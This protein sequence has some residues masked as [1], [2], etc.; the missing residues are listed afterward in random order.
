M[1]EVL[2]DFLTESHEC[3]DLIDVGLANFRQDPDNVDLLHTVFRLVHT[4]KGTCGFL[5]LPRLEALSHAAESMIYRFRLDATTIS[6]DGVTLVFK[7]LESIKHLLSQIEVHE[8][9]EPAGDDSLLIAELEEMAGGHS[10]SAGASVV[11]PGQRNLSQSDL[12]RLFDEASEVVVPVE[13]ALPSS[14]IS[15]A[16]EA[17]ASRQMLRVKV[18]SLEQLVSTVTDLITTRAH[19]LEI[20]RRSDDYELKT[21]VNRLA[22]IASHLQKIVVDTRVQPIGSAWRQLL[23]MTQNLAVRLNK[24]IALVLDGE[25]IEVDRQIIDLIKAPL[26]HMV[27]N[28]ADHGL[29]APDARLALGKPAQ[30]TI[31]VTAVRHGSDIVIEVLDDGQGLNTNKIKQKAL[32]LGLINDAE[33]SNMDEADAAQLIFEPGLSTC[34]TVTRLS[35]R[36]VGLDVAC[37]SIETI[38]GSIRVYSVPGEGTVFVI[39]IPVT[40]AQISSLILAKT[41]DDEKIVL[42]RAKNGFAELSSPSPV[43]TDAASQ[44]K[45]AS[46]PGPDTKV[47]FLEENPFFKSMLTPAIEAGGYDVTVV[48]SVSEALES[49]QADAPFLA[50]VCDLDAPDKSGFLLAKRVKENPDWAGIP[51]VAVSSLVSSL[52]KDRALEAGFDHCLAKFDRSALRS[53]L[54]QITY[55][56]KVAA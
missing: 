21:A 25:A 6:P 48:E 36:G 16:G 22:D 17:T 54:N 2:K 46:L 45:P 56:L 26:A 24:D 39:R 13:P 35:G 42:N 50:I 8:G 55:R 33:Y 12:D 7:S 23:P 30:G 52:S 34:E 47:L 41:R 18:E 51:L 15:K 20:A 31:G 53:C 14:S 3:L 27:R 29:E 49:L 1:D 38:G 44:Q 40:P 10:G 9:V 37:N 28:S 19:L 4:M 32:A 43:L 11:P 5:N